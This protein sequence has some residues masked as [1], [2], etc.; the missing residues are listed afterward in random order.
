MQGTG[1]ADSQ[2]I[3]KGVGIGSRL[4]AASVVS[5]HERGIFL[6][7]RSSSLLNFPTSI[8]PLKWD[9][10]LLSMSSGEKRFRGYMLFRLILARVV[11]KWPLLGIISLNPAVPPL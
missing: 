4:A 3:K 6:W 1:K 2:E 11:S 5:Y 8:S 10:E 7:D 9:T